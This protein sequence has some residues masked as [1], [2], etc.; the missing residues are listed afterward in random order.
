[1]IT[2][3]KN[4]K[5]QWVRELQSRTRRRREENA[6][7]IEGVRL[8]EEALLAAWPTVLVL[9]TEDLNPR[10]QE[11]VAGLAA[12]GAAVKSVSE[13][14]M[15]AAS[16]TQ[17][18]QGILAALSL[19]PLPAPEALDFVFIPDGVRDPG[20]LGTMLRSAAAAG[21][22]A[23]LLPPGAADPFAPKVL[24]AGMGA[25]FHLPIISYGWPEITAHLEV[26]QLR[27]YLAA[28][29]QGVPYTAVDFRQP[30]ALVIGGE[31][32]GAGAEAQARAAGFVHIPMPGRME[33]LNAGSAAAV[34]LFEAARQRQNNTP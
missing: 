1:M 2:S 22:Q 7:V 11:I 6:F 26:Y 14:V 17:T 8:A 28:A 21:V 24:R 23:V 5:I 32:E 27:L 15:S 9:Y 30:F 20:N 3:T 13:A 31:A 12:Q 29:R 18:P 4:P 19:R 33:S 16:D 10:G 25:H 34:L